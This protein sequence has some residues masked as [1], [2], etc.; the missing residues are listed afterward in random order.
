M[1][2]VKCDRCGK[3]VEKKEWLEMPL[4]EINVMTETKGELRKIDLCDDCRDTFL[5]WINQPKGE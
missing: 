2:I 5:R 3:E 4:I 1:I